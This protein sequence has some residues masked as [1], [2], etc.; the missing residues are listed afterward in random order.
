MAP[1]DT[2]GGGKESAVT[3]VQH[4]KQYQKRRRVSIILIVANLLYE[5]VIY[6]IL[7]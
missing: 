4:I 1:G 2:E 6:V 7:F 5:Y 3:G